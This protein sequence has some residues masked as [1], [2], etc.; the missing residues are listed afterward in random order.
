M[1]GALSAGVSKTHDGAVSCARRMSA[2]F[3]SRIVSARCSAKI[4]SATRSSS[5]ASFLSPVTAL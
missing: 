1:N 5:A 2:V 4:R 3:M